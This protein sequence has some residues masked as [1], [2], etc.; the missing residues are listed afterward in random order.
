M[1][2]Q[3]TFTTTPQVQIVFPERFPVDRFA[4]QEVTEPITEYMQVGD[5]VHMADDRLLERVAEY[6]DFT[7]DNMTNL[8][9][10]RPADNNIVIME[11][12]SYG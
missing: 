6:Y 10:A 7:P 8:T 12:P 9:V 11:K 2:D 5:S 4:G 3:L 1:T